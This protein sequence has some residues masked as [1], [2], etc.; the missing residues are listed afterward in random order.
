MRDWK[1]AKACLCYS[2]TWSGGFAAGVDQDGLAALIGQP[3]QQWPGD[4]LWAVV[5]GLVRTRPWTH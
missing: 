1:G 4:E 3:L 2:H 5:S